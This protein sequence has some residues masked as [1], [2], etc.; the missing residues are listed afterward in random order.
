MLGQELRLTVGLARPD[1]GSFVWKGIP[2]QSNA[3]YAAERV[4]IGHNY[5]LNADLTES[6]ALDFLQQLQGRRYRTKTGAAT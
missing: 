2:V 3:A 4:Y 1:A 6:A 5:C